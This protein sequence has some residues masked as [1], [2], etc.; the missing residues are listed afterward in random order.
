M[1]V[2]VAIGGV[3]VKISV[4]ICVYVDVKNGTKV[5]ILVF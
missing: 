2:C 1:V 5:S 4:W 3:N